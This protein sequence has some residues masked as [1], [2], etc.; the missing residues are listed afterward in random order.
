MAAEKVKDMQMPRAKG[1]VK[2]PMAKMEVQKLPPEKA[3]A[4]AKNI[5]APIGQPGNKK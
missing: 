5:A 4:V 3:K 2:P 1:M